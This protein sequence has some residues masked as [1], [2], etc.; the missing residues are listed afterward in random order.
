MKTLD[1]FEHFDAT[2]VE[3]AAALLAR[4][5]EKAWVVAGGTDV[6]G[7][8][9]FEILPGYPEALVNLKTI[10]GLDYIREEGD[11]LR[12]GALTRLHDIATSPV[13]QKYTALAQAAG[14]T[15]SPHVREMGTIGGNICQLIRCWYFRKEENRF[16][17]IRKGGRLCHA[18]LGDN[19]YH[20]IFGAVRVGDPPCTQYCPAGP[21]IPGYL[22]A[23]RDD[24]FAAA[25]A[26]LLEY[27]PLAAVTGRVCPRFC[28]QECNRNELDEAV[29]IR[30]IERSVGDYLLDHAGSLYRAPRAETGKK[31]AVIGSGPA[32]LT[33]AYYLRT[34]GH[35]V[36]VFEALEEPG[37]ML[38][39][40]IPPYRLPK[41]VVDR[42]VKALERTGVT[43]T[44]TTRVGTDISLAALQEEY[45]AVF[46][47]TG[48]WQQPSLGIGDEDLLTSGLE[49]LNAVNHGSREVA[50]GKVLVVG[51]G[52]VAMDI[53]ITLRRLGVADVTVTCLECEDEM[54]AL[55]EEVDQAVREG[56]T[57]LPSWGPARV[58]KQDG[59]LTG[60]ELKRCVA[61]YDADHRFAP[62]YDTSVKREVEAD[63]VILAI[64]QRPDL[65]F[66]DESVPTARGLIVADPE[67]QTTELAGFFA[68]GDATVPSTSA[69]VVA[70]ITAGRRAAAAINAY[71]GGN[72]MPQ[73][74]RKIEHLQRAANEL[75]ETLPRLKSSGPAVSGVSLTSEDVPGTD[76]DLIV[77]ETK[78][79]L[80]C[81]CDGVNPSDIAPTL[82]ALDATIVTSKRSLKA[83]DF[84]A[85]DRGLKSTVLE[86]DEMV[87]EIRIP[88]PKAGA[89][90]SFIKFA[91]RRS[92]DFPIV[93]CAAVIE[94][95]NG[96]IKAAR[97]CLNAV[98]S[99]P[100]R[101]KKAEEVIIGKP[102]DEASANAAGEASVAGAIALPYNKFKIQIAK[103]MVKRSILGCA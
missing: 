39:Y 67:S 38:R 16:D 18:V 3:E 47:S 63:M 17:C 19:R 31:V 90:S 50:A 100:Y 61:C 35:T 46:C 25:A 58:L 73:A 96:I 80:N 66:L 65:S 43:F 42:Q 76:P 1:T 54:P 9:R 98:Y 101:V 74:A 4:Y 56:V 95:D 41:D 92:I 11:T 44:C 86:S 89:R 99:N 14:Q 22:A 64:G 83:D 21:D 12:I 102:L 93:N 88:K 40:G 20:S 36:N 48:A 78:R 24:D 32:G 34:S 28:E 87:T 29:S 97:I 5:G 82:I 60:M 85:A 94:A 69:F 7:A 81:G 91:M 6:I 72:S 23:V 68:G 52:S 70:A 45:D 2:S 37:G 15:A 59:R 57:L 8:M 30:S 26:S 103:T 51:G 75:L 62:E 10:R 79:C 55:R 13:T 84:W 49:F 53:A 77:T 33:A 71:L 27:N